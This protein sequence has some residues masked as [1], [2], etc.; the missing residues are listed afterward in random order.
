LTPLDPPPPVPDFVR[1]QG[2]PLPH[3]LLRSSNSSLANLLYMISFTD[4][5]VDFKQLKVLYGVRFE[6]QISRGK[7]ME[8]SQQW[9]YWHTNVKLGNFSKGSK[10]FLF[11]IF[12]H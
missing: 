12:S 5:L 6:Q 1:K 8:A 11:F 3:Y 9:L 2:L 4:T 7:T 10:A